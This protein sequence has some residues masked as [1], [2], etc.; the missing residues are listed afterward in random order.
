MRGGAEQ[1][2]ENLVAAL[3]GAGHRVDLVRLPVAW[4]KG[5]LFDAPLAW[6]MVPL[7]ADLVIATNFPSYFVRHPNKVVWLLH[8]HRGAY[9]GFAA[10]ASWSDFGLDDTSLEEQR[11]MTEWDAAALGEARRVYTNSG[12][13]SRRLARFNGLT[14][15]PLA[16]PPPMADVLHPGPYGDYVLSVQRQEANKRPGLLVEA[17]AELA[18][19][20]SGLRAVLAGRGELLEPL[21]ARVGELGLGDRV[22][23]PGFVPDAEVVDLFAGALA[24]VY[25]PEDEDYGYATL[26][27][28]HAGKPVVCAADSGGVLDWVEDGVTGLVTDGSPA[29]I[30]AALARLDADRDLARRMGEA[31]RARVRELSWPAV[32][33]EL[34][35][36]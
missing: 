14:G 5:R 6:R 9:D 28:F 10:G 32:V 21:R 13:V 1:H 31:G 8:Q 24:V 4:E 34:T 33:T 25:A 17:M 16:H 2:Q 36:P 12:V 18:G 27:A 11:L 30:A 26:Q 3:A 20:G 22:Q 29:G 7:D 23:V 19:T 35:R 15:T